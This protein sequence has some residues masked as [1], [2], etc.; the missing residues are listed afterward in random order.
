MSSSFR[1]LIPLMNRVLV[2]KLT[3]TAN[4][5]NSIIMSSKV[6]EPNVGKIVAVGEGILS[7]NGKRVPLCVEIDST[8]LL[9]EFGGQKL[10]LQEG[11]FYL[12]RD[13]EIV[14]I[15]EE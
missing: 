14:G 2:K 6:A 8:V 13:S 15:L 9:P 3:P 5:K 7:E 4:T 10:V 11:E 12:F 1:K